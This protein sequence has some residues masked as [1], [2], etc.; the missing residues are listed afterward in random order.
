MGHFAHNGSLRSHWVAC[1]TSLANHSL[2]NTWKHLLKNIDEHTQLFRVVWWR[3]GSMLWCNIT[4][5]VTFKICFIIDEQTSYI[6][7]CLR[8]SRHIYQ[9]LQLLFVHGWYSLSL[10]VT[11]TS[12]A[13]IITLNKIVITAWFSCLSLC[14]DGCRH[15]AIQL[16][17]LSM[18][19]LGM[20]WGHFSWQLSAMWWFVC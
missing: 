3:C 10:N 5:L 20:C 17:V 1:V 9:A 2:N 8:S 19:T 12:L 11:N 15:Q 16:C 6:A 4:W 13:C 14:L 18:M 7:W